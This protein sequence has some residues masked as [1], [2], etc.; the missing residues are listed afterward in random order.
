MN[1]ILINYLSYAPTTILLAVDTVRKFDLELNI[2]L[3]GVS[4]TLP[5]KLDFNDRTVVLRKTGHKFS[6]NS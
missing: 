3:K 6:L 4:P 2:G 1:Y 5:S